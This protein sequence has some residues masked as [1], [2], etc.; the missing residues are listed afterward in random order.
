[1]RIRKSAFAG[2]LAATIA[3]AGCTP[4]QLDR[5]AA[6][7]AQFAAACRIA[8]AS[9]WASP[10]VATVCGGEALIARFYFDPEIAAWVAEIAER[11][12]RG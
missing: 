11:V 10:W 2:A 3:L 4:A 1:M 8:M 7:H 6:L 9:P 12:R 5:A